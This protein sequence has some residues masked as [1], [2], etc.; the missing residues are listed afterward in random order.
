LKY[1]NVKMKKIVVREEYCPKNHSCPTVSRC[2]FGAIIQD[3][4][5]EA[6]RIDDS[7][8][9]DCG[10]CTKTCMVFDCNGC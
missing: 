10:L 4:P 5:F 3:S 9:T 6:P 1:N 7:K 2:P 8:C